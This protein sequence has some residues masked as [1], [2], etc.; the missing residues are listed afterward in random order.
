[1]RQNKAYLH[2]GD[3]E[4][5]TNRIVL[6]KK[7]KRFL[8]DLRIYLFSS[9]K[10][11]DEIEDIVEELQV[12]LIE[13]E[14]DGKSIDNI[15]GQSP[16][17]YMDQI[18]DEMLTDYQEWFTYIVIIVFGSF[19][20]IIMN[21]LFQGSVSY[22]LLEIIGYLSIATVFIICVFQ[23]FKYIAA[24][25]LSK[26]VEYVIF[27]VLGLLPISLYIGLIFLNEVIETPVIHLEMLGMII[28]AILTLALLLAIS[29]WAK[30]WAMLIILALLILPDTVLHSF[31]ISETLH[32]LLGTSISFVGIAIYL[33]IH[34]KLSRAHS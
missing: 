31:H 11:A 24:H 19:G 30:T 13:A 12:H 1:M 14:R 21:D 22:S 3:V 26:I 10:N 4:M 34:S 27:Y 33:V 16:K 23:A 29:Y 2:K 17:A 20:F 6:S 18:S 7:S 15:V 5:N 9:G 32:L 25:N 8:E 28:T